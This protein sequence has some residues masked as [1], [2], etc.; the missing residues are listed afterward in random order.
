MSMQTDTHMPCT[1]THAATQR[2][3]ECVFVCVCAVNEVHVC[4]CVHT[5]KYNSSSTTSISN[6]ML[7]G[8]GAKRIQTAEGG[9]EGSVC[10]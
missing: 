3:T 8:L 7:A 6:G 1:Y 2:A 4:A 9:R 10:V 5:E